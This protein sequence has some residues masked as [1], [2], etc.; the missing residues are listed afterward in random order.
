MDFS[1]KNL[2]GRGKL[3]ES[4]EA[5]RKPLLERAVNKGESDRTLER[6]PEVRSFG[7]EDKDF[8]F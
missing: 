6:Y 4:P 8:G 5:S 1:G 2:P 7:D 3:S